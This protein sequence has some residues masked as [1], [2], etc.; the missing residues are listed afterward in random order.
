MKH[1]GLQIYSIRDQFTNEEDTKNAFLEIKKMGYSYAQTAGTYDYIAPE[2]FAQYAKDA[3]IEICGTHYKWD[4]IKNDIEGTIAYHKILGT[5]NIGIGGMPPEA[6]G[7]IN[8][9]NAF[10]DE[11]NALAREYYKHGFKL[12]YHNHA[13]EFAKLSDGRTL[14]D[15]MIEKFDPECTSF[16][17]D[18]HWVQNAGADVRAMIERLRGR[19]DILHLKDMAYSRQELANGKAISAP[20]IIEIGAGNI[21]FKDI[22]PLAEECGVKYFVVEDDRCI[23]G[24]SLATNKRSAD[25]LIQNFLNK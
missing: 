19:I 11:F 6:R 7:D 17:L 18:V 14:F 24:E 15:H 21:N 2:K 13:F 10:I 22:I 25:Y 9:L 16:V 1:F 23:P 5:T 20:V 4:I 8:E 12:T 3:G